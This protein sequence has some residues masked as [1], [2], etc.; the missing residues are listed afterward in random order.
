[1]SPSKAFQEVQSC[2]IMVPQRLTLVVELSSIQCLFCPS[3][4][5]ND[6]VRGGSLE[7][8]MHKFLTWSLCTPCHFAHE[9]EA[10]GFWPVIP[11]FSKS[12]VVITFSSI[13]FSSICKG[14]L[15]GAHALCFVEV[16]GCCSNVCLTWIYIP[17]L[18]WGM[19]SCCW[20][21]FTSH[22]FGLFIALDSGHLGFVRFILV[23]WLYFPR[24]WVSFFFFLTFWLLYLLWVRCIVNRVLFD[25][26][27]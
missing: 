2:N 1:M 6:F 14:N 20:R 9:V 4:W 23:H 18:A 17:S 24:W 8:L 27:A 21:V 26:D 7:C 16:F 22:L 11:I 15:Q 19:I 3:Y 13:S 5:D 12:M 25:P 10:R